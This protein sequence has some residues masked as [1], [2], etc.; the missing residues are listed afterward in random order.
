MIGFL[1]GRLPKRTPDAALDGRYDTHRGLH[2]L[3]LSGDDYEMGYQHGALL[4]DAMERGPVP[5]FERYVERML[6]GTLGNAGARVAAGALRRTVGRKIARQF[7]ERA[8]RGLDGLADGAGVSRA[9]LRRGVTMPETYLWVLQRLI[10]SRGSALAPRHGVPTLGCTSALAWGGATTDGTMLHGRNLD[11]QGI[12]AWDTEQAVVFHR[13]DDGQRYVSVSAAGILFGGV[14]AMNGAGL[15]L[16]V[17]Q[18]MAS[19]AFKL[20]GTPIGITGDDVMRY[21]KTLDDAKRILDSHTPSGCWTYVIGSAHE[22][23]VL[24]YEVT[25]SHRGVVQMEGETF[26]Y[27]NIYLHPELAPTERHIYPSHWRNNAARWHRANGILEAAVGDITPETI[28]AIMGDRGEA[29][30]RFEQAIAMVMTVASVVFRPDDG[31][32]W[33]GTGRAPTSN[34][35]FAAFDLETEGP[36]ADLPELVAGVPAAEVAEAFDA[37][38]AACEAQFERGDSAAAR[39]SM[40]RARALQP[41]EPLFHYVAGLLAHLDADPAAAESAFDAALSVGHGEPQR[42]ASFH[43]WRGRARDR[44]GRRAEA[45]ADY[46]AA[47]RDADPFTRSAAEQGLSRRWKPRRFGIEFTLADVPMP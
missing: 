19:D 28:A 4:R 40:E 6:A 41:E 18:H 24:C 8:L 20:G 29:G 35:P 5:Y 9:A 12:G 21:A 23:D 36:R 13:P 46:R 31:V 44:L 22:K 17:H 26:G 32:V 39:R 25:P 27:S 30:C 15:T 33:V 38:R 16:A 1:L 37:Y 7:P 3:R 34:R 10:D 14:T 11:Y 45:E 47:S 2:V 42:R 43:L